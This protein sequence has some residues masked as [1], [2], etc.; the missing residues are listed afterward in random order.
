[1]PTLSHT[2]VQLR[3][4]YPASKR[5][6]TRPWLAVFILLLVAAVAYL[7]M[8]AFNVL[9]SFLNPFD[10]RTTVRNSPVTI[11]SIRDMNRYVAAEGEFQVIVDIQ[12]SRDNIP[13][14]LYGER[15][16]LVAVGR[17][18][19]SVDSS[20]IADDDLEVS[21]TSVRLTLPPPSLSTPAL[22]T[23]RSY[24]LAHEAGV[25]NRI[26]DVFGGRQVDQMALF[27]QAEQQ[28]TGAAEQSDLSA[29]A[30]TNTTKM[31]TT[32]F[33]R[34]GYDRVTISYRGAER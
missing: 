13:E 10:S 30:Q 16:V 27:H 29:R 26:A 11:E 9:P 14:F 24:V 18:D 20:Q 2:E 22:D 7:G 21:G 4:A 32:L 31:L 12:Q 17:V 6:R 33:N 8:N 15:T 5:R 28:I 34:L 1:M 3:E 23:E 25:A 19:A